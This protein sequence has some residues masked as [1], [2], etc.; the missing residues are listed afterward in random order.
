MDKLKV[1]R[2]NRKGTLTRALGGLRQLVDSQ[3]S[4]QELQEGLLRVKRTFET[5][6]QSHA[7]LVELIND[8]DEFQKEEDWMIRCQKEYMAE[9]HAI[10]TEYKTK[11]VSN[12]LAAKAIQ[13][14]E[15]ETLEKNQPDTIVNDKVNNSENHNVVDQPNVVEANVKNHNNVSNDKTEGTWDSLVKALSLPRTPLKHYDGDPVYYHS[16]ITSYQ[17]MMSGVNDDSVKLNTLILFCKGKALDAIQFCVMKPPTEGFKAA[18]DTLR[19]RFG[20]TA[21]IVQAWVQK[22]LT[23]GKVN[24]H[25]LREFSDD[26]ENCYEALSALGYLNELNNQA[27]VKQIIDGLPKFLQ[28]RWCRENQKIKAKGT[29]PSLKDIVMFVKT[30]ALETSDPVFGNQEQQKPQEKHKVRVNQIAAKTEYHKCWVCQNDDHWTDQCEAM[31]KLSSDER[32][33]MVKEKHACFACLKIAG[34][35]HRMANCTRR[36]RC[37]KLVDKQCC[38]KY[39]HPL[40]HPEVKAGNVGL[41]GLSKSV[42]DNEPLLQVLEVEVING[43]TSKKANVMLD[44]GSQGTFIREGFVNSLGIQGKNVTAALTTVGGKEEKYDTKIYDIQLVGEN[45]KKIHEIKAIGM[46]DISDN[47]DVDVR[48]L[49]QLFEMKEGTLKRQAGPIDILIGVNYAHLHTGKILEGDGIVAQKCPLGW[50]VYGGGGNS[51]L[52]NRIM[53][54]KISKPVDL[55]DFWSTEAMGVD[56]GSCSC[57]KSLIVNEG[58]ET[59]LLEDSCIKVEN[60]WTVPYPWVRDPSDLMDNKHQAKKCWVC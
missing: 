3:P 44:N 14:V 6:E 29:N 5:I 59:K 52:N 51:T 17:S 49:E 10:K 46:S 19:E 8:D 38:D 15:T 58:M 32:M 7:E 53:H 11:T 35:N 9:V 42:I 27:S 36:K 47:L 45:P 48:K 40:L 13:D 21:I 37:N 28:N 1:T 34:R 2:R 16:F 57:K 50:T 43:N 22:I 60:Q 41:V 55:T 24:V 39:H 18:W 26:I 31:L 30:A 33:K 4:E 25:S 54:V 20:N 56:V 12:N 23:R